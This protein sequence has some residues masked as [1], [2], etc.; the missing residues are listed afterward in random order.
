VARSGDGRSLGLDTLP[1]MRG[2][3]RAQPLPDR[4]IH[5]GIV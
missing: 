1:K 5:S 3:S 4:R 2:T